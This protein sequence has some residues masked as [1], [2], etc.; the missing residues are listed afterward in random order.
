MS[1][2]SADQKAQIESIHKGE[3]AKIDELDKQSLT[4]AQYR[5]QMIEIRKGTQTQV[6]SVLTPDQKAKVAA[7]RER[8]PGGPGGPGGRRPPP[9]SN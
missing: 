1:S 3:R 2:L 9:Q 6:E 4:Q 7:A 8:G 5:A